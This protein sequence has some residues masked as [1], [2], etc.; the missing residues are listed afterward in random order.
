MKKI[1]CYAHICPK[2][3]MDA[4]ENTERGISRD[5]IAQDFSITGGESIW[6]LEKRLQVMDRYEDYVQVLVPTGEVVEPFFGPRDADYLTRTFNDAVADIVHRHPD[7]FVAAVATLPLNDT[8][9]ALKEIDRAIME[10]GFKGVLL[11]TPVFAFDEDRPAEMG[12]NYETMKPIDSPEFLPIYE[13]MSEHNLPIWIHPVGQGGVPV[14]R[15]ETRAKF[16]LA[17]I[18]GWPIESAMAMSRL[19]CGGILKKYPN[20]RFIIHHC[21]SAVVPALAGRIDNEFEKLELAGRLKWDQPGEESPFKSKRA[22]D[23]FKMFYGDTALYGG[24]AELDMGHRFFGS[25]HILFGTDYPYDAVNGDKFIKK[26]IDAVY[27]MNI[28]DHER[29]LIFEGNIKR[30]LR[31]DM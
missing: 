10:L 27:G 20:L 26:T 9:A 31:L 19:V 11:H 29:E 12:L 28:S 23:Y 14:Y 7:R 25:E 18:F 8:D 13:R 2:E 17:H 1:D 3:F 21:G 24:I 4:F 15:G 6:N 5:K 30:I 16:G 22:I